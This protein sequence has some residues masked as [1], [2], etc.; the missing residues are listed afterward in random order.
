MEGKQEKEVLRV[1]VWG[2]E[3]RQCRL[4]YHYTFLEQVQVLGSMEAGDTVSGPCRPRRGSMLFARADLFTGIST[5]APL[6]T[7]PYRSTRPPCL[8]HLGEI[9]SMLSDHASTLLASSYSPCLH[10]QPCFLTELPTFGS[11]TL[12]HFHSP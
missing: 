1:G 11:L 9:T 7:F 2:G 6:L 10:S 5:P 3:K 12:P 8:L 4:T